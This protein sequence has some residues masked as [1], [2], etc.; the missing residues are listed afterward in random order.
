MLGGHGPCQPPGSASVASSTLIRP[1]IP[2]LGS[3]IKKPPTAPYKTL[4]FVGLLFPPS[5]LK[6]LDG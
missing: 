2:N 3:G 6:G 4:R 1:S 5:H